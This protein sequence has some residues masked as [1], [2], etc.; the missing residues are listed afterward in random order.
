MWTP[1]ILAILLALWLPFYISTE[2]RWT[3]NK[4]V[5]TKMTASLLFIAIGVSAFI[6]SDAPANYGAW[7]VAALV[8]GMVGDLLLVYEDKSLFFVLGLVSFL[9]GQIIYGVTFLRFVGFMWIDVVL[10]AVLVAAAIFAYTRVKLDLGKMK[11]PVLAYLLIIMFMFVMAL[12]SI[13]K[14]G[15]NTLTSA[16]ISAGA[17]LFL[18]SD[19]VL[20][21][22]LFQKNSPKPLRAINLSL[23]Y[24]AQMLLALSVLTLGVL[25]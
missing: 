2:Y 19:V 15:F 10:Y 21:F 3:K 5:F 1:V 22:F 16:F 18:A 7:V 4:Y 23:Y 9:I 6:V 24:G 11:V 17:V 12:S 8:F 25:K 20:A 13:Y 14:G